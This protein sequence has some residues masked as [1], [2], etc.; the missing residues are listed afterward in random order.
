[1]AALSS[2][3]GD[4]RPAYDI[5]VVGSG[6]GGS[7]AARR[8]SQKGKNASICVLERGIERQP[9]HFPATIPAALGQFQIDTR[10]GRV[11]SRTAL[12]DMRVNH[13]VSVLVG[14]GLGGTSLINAGVMIE[15]TE[16]VK[17]DPKWP[18]ALNQL[19]VLDFA[20]TRKVLGAG[21]VP[22]AIDLPK[23]EQLRQA[24]LRVKD[25]PVFTRPDIA[26]SFV[27]Q[28]NDG[29]APPRT[30]P[31]ACSW[32][33]PTRNARSSSAASTC[34]ASSQTATAAGGCTPA[35]PTAPGAGS[36]SPS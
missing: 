4:L 35:L 20:A 2:P 12:F 30:L 10:L 6:Y 27:S 7:I 14:C 32:R 18:G 15:P 13:D 29:G 26:V 23:G 17:N 34:A 3:L 9:G 19:A 24:S 28:P 1:M 16:S 31:T 22:I 36:A 8:M 11:G 5:V 21:P 25:P 33:A